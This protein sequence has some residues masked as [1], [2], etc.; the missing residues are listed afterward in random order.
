M[1]LENLMKLLYERKISDIEL[2]ENLEVLVSSGVTAKDID[3]VTTFY[4]GNTFLCIAS[5]KNYI[6]SVKYLISIGCDVNLKGLFGYTPLINA[7]IW[8]NIEVVKLLLQYGAETN[9]P[10]IDNHTPLMYATL[11]NN[12]YLVELLLKYG[13][14]PNTIDNYGISAKSLAY[15]N[16]FTEIYE[17]FSEKT[18]VLSK[19]EK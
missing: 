1:T 8:N 10:N 14:N 18:M 6:E 13:A 15:L 17:M 5:E 9:I 16:N 7:C 12:K 4:K 11:S 19:G 2:K 3:R